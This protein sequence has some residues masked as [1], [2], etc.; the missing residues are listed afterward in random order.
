M[1]EYKVNEAA[2]TL[3]KAIREASEAIADGA[4]VAQERNIKY[5]QS[6]FLDGIE[7]LKSDRESTQSLIQEL[8][9]QS[10]KQ[11]AALQALLHEAVDAYVGFLYTPFS[12]YK[13]TMDYADV[14][15]K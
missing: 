8:V 1:T 15:V 12:Y 11:R 14:A 7:V 2:W 6:I 5:A 9:E 13:Q 3:V 10:Q 4:V